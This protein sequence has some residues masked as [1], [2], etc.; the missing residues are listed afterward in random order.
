MTK[1]R[2]SN[3]PL[4][5]ETGRYTNVDR[6]MRLC[7]F[8]SSCIEDETHF[9]LHCPTYNDLRYK[10]L[11]IHILENKSISD[12]DKLQKLMKSK[13]IKPV[14]KFISDAF[15][16]RKLNIEIKSD[17]TN[18]GIGIEIYKDDKL[19]I[20]KYHGL[21]SVIKI[22]RAKYKITK[23]RNLKMSIKLIS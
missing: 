17:T 8:C 14:A 19:M 2:L 18:T 22:T 1:L 10:L 9:L 23:K 20:T 3:H 13:H 11:P 6:K 15:E 12:I 5:I 4:Y 16:L 21:T 7:P